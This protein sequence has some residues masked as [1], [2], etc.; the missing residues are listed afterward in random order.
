MFGAYQEMKWTKI[1]LPV[2]LRVH[3]LLPLCVLH[4]S[5]IGVNL[6]CWMFSL[7]CFSVSIPRPP[8]ISSN[9]ACPRE[10]RWHLHQSQLK[11]QTRS[12]KHKIFAFSITEV[13]IL[14]SAWKKKICGITWPAFPSPSPSA[15]G[16]RRQRT[17]TAEEVLENIKIIFTIVAFQQIFWPLNMTL[18]V[19][20]N[21]ASLS[22]L[23]DNVS[24]SHCII[25]SSF[26]HSLLWILKYF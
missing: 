26:S 24:L 6:A 18:G 25:F 17:V 10:Y 14:I 20:L 8:S 23:G 5:F 4:R 7:M 3:L 15:L 1:P 19:L 2:R 16:K 21:L 11:N 13:A 12:R 22:F 9:R